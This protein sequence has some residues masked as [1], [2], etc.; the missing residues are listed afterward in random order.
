MTRR[1][2]ATGIASLGTA[3]AIVWC[4]SIA[5]PVS[6]APAAEPATIRVGATT[7]DTSSEVYYAQ[8]RG[9]FKSRN[10]T[11]AI[12]SLR[13][14]A[15]IAAAV[16]GG[17]LDVGEQ[18]MISG[19]SAHERGVP[20]TFITPAGAYV[21]KSPTTLLVVKKS[22]PIHSAKDLNGKTVAVQALKDLTQIGTAEWIDKHGGDPSSV[23]FVEVPAAQVGEVLERGTVDAATVPEPS[24]TV[25]RPFVRE[26]GRPYDA[27]ASHFV[28]N[29][30][31]ATTDWVK[32]NPSAARRFVDA[33]AEAGRWANANH[34][35]S[36][37]ILKHYSKISPD[38]IDS[39]TRAT[40][41]DR[42]STATL[43]PVID[44]AAKYKAIAK[45]FPA[46]ELYDASL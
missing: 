41:A 46:S 22:S 45:S 36:A 23:H 4:A 1:T 8:E 33:I 11:V 19:S 5:R 3:A 40:Y 2:I 18:N 15:A 31:F 27:I 44:S 25:A 13:S 20:L 21:S 26:I 10:L 9:Y 37:E 32:K 29:G 17:S 35:A 42:F 12:E 6:A 24:L 43:Q 34:K 16:V 30:W 38:V 7:N 39:M 28:I 14:G